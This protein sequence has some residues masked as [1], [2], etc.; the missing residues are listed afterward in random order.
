MDLPKVCKVGRRR[1]FTLIETVVAFGILAI[2]IFS[3]Y[4]A[5][6]FGFTTIRL[7][8][9]NVRA[10]QILMQKMETI[11][12]YHWSQ[13]FNAGYLPSTFQTSFSP[14]SANPGVTYDGTITITNFPVS[15][16]NE[17]YADSLRQTT[18][19]LN[20]TSEVQ[21]GPG[22]SP[23]LFRNMAFRLSNTK[24]REAFT[25]VEMLVAVPLCC[26]LLAG[27]VSLYC[28]T[29]TS[30]ASLTSYTSLNQKARMASDFI[31]RDVREATSVDDTTVTNRL[32]LNLPS[33]GVTYLYNAGAGTLVRSN[34][35]EVRQLLTNVA[36]LSF[37]LYQR[38]TNSALT[39][40]IAAG[41][42]SREH[43][44][45]WI[46]LEMREAD[47]G[48]TLRFAGPGVGNSRTEEPMRV[49]QK[50][51]AGESGNS[52]LIVMITIG[53][54]IAALGTYL[55]LTSQENKTVMRSMCWNNALPLAEAGIEE[56][57]S[58]LAR[59]TNGYA[60]DGWAANGTNFSK[61]RSL[62]N[63]YYNVS[64]SGD[65]DTGVTITST[66]AVQWTM[67]V[68]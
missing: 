23:V 14:N 61:Q 53:L 5:L 1:A 55:A 49:I 2:V 46:Q 54:L 9:E 50:R 27:L 33:G 66:G 62:G 48:I 36:T 16:A 63:D 10:D 51:T 34:S 40:R 7:S 52:L 6:S 11:R 22:A 13:V 12:V 64:F 41:R 44:A 26:L 4:A 65:L 29:T 18:V 38:P 20:W 32:V 58:H 67:E 42:Q 60:I 17:S 37:S 3:L 68:T 25:L 24:R 47:C 56:A 45:G 39:Y 31:S 30:F 28:Y 35:A 8:Q 15:A 59:N 43:Q 21:C 19:T 57:M